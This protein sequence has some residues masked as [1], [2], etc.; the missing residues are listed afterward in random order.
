MQFIQT[1]QR[2]KLLNFSSSSTL[3]KV[4]TYHLLLVHLLT[5][6]AH[7]AALQ[8][9]SALYLADLADVINCLTFSYTD[10]QNASPSLHTR[11]ANSHGAL[12]EPR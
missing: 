8:G 4:L 3:G 1:E 10:L 2:E 12:S 9:G 6:G 7:H 11:A 5:A